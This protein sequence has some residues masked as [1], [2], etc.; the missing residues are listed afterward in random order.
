MISKIIKFIR[1]NRYPNIETSGRIGPSY[2]RG[3]EETKNILYNRYMDI[4]T[5]KG[6]E[7]S[8][9]HVREEMV[10]GF[11]AVIFAKDI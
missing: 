4:Y 11:I 1:D 8:G 10:N 3:T 7:Y 9:T 2:Y 5:I 6:R